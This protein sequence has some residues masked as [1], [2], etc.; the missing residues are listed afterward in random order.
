MAKPIY[1]PFVNNLS[2]YIQEALQ[3]FAKQFQTCIPAIV[4]SVEDRNTV[5][6]SPAVLQTSADG[7]PVKWADITTTVLTPFSSGVFLSMPVAVGD[8][9]WLV[10]AD[11]DTD[12]FKQT[13]KPAQQ[14]IFTR[15]QYQFGFFVPDAING[16]TV[17]EDDNGAWVLSS[18]DGNTKIVLKD[19]SI[20]LKSKTDLKINAKNITIKS[21]NNANVTIDG[22]NFKNHTHGLPTGQNGSL[23]ANLS[24]GQVSGITD[25]VTVLP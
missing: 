14:T 10:G 13:K 24:N 16:Y 6:V 21:D 2:G 17:S 1:N 15:H 5:T 8:T 9:G 19:G 7:L 20:D 3:T 11:L 23:V 12:K 18:T 4:K 25:K 22:V